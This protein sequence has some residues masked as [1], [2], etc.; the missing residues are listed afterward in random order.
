M[1]VVFYLQYKHQVL[2]IYGDV[3]LDKQE[4]ES[5]NS[6]FKLIVILILA[7]LIATMF[8]SFLN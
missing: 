5:I 7:L 4:L 8:I 6:N 2:T 1:M 3:T